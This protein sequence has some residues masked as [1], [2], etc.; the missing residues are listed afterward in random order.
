M[1]HHN[2]IVEHIVH[3][4]RLLTECYSV[5]E[6]LE[7]SPASFIGLNENRLSTMESSF[8]RDAALI[9]LSRIYRGDKDQDIVE[10]IKELPFFQFV[11]EYHYTPQGT[12][13]GA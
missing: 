4:Y 6:I 3:K 2:C 12:E 10:H 11:G 13:N 5:S 1:K 9:T 7:L 8:F